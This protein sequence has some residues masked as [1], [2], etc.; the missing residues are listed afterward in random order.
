MNTGRFG[1]GLVA[2]GVIH[3]GRQGVFC[4]MIATLAPGAPLALSL[5]LAVRRNRRQSVARMAGTPSDTDA[6]K[7]GV[8]TSGIQGRALDD[9]VADVAERRDRRAFGQLFDHFAPRLKA[10]LARSGADQATAE[11]VVQDVMLTLWRRA[12]QFD[13]TQASVGTWIYTIARNRRIDLLRRERRPEIDPADP[14]LA[15][16]PEPAADDTL[17]TSER[18]RRL[19]GALGE[20]P[21]EQAELLRMAFF[22]DKPHSVIAAETRLPLG[23]VKSRLRLAMVRLRKVLKDNL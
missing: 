23:T 20:L 7:V 13:R 19:R 17:L 11:E 14:L 6:S 10:Y 2:G 21:A 3:G 8:A 1:K 18:E 22:D 16:A 15:P 9:L 4:L 12:E 5:H